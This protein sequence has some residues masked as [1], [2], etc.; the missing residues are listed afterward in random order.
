MPDKN[1]KKPDSDMSEW[2]NTKASFRGMMTLPGSIRRQ[3]MNEPKPGQTQAGDDPFS[4]ARAPMP[5]D[6]K[7]PSPPG[8]T[9]AQNLSAP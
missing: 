8:V 7:R 5:E 9:Y 6:V 1:T 2:E 3:Y 4:F